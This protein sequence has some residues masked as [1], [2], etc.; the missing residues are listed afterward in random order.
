MRGVVIY[1]SHFGKDNKLFRLVEDLKFQGT[2][3]GIDLSLVGND[4]IFIVEDGGLR[5]QFPNGIERPDF[6]I[7]WD[8][9]VPLAR[10]LKKLGYRVYN[11]PKSIEVCDD[12][13]LTTFALQGKVKMPKTIIG[14]FSYGKKIL[15]ENYIDRVF[16]ELGESIIVKESKGSFGMQVHLVNSRSELK[17]VI[18]SL[19]NRP[20][21]LQEYISTSKGRDIRVNIVGDKIIGAMER[22][23]QDDFRANITIGGVA[24][25][26]DLTP[27]ER[28]IALKA[29]RILGLTFSG[30]DLLY[31]ENGPILCEVNS[32]VNYLS[33][34]KLTGINMGREILKLITTE[35]YY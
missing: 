24:K 12:K 27:E 25:K 17:N 15:T 22:I 11:S 28:N 1:N 14:S 13:I 9:D 18:E 31:G 21:L 6:I 4:E 30:V 16:N 5:V 19:D 32:N 8:K 3:M 29:H 35:L 23:N 7:F 10:A 34:E 20:F 33:F 2:S 26:I